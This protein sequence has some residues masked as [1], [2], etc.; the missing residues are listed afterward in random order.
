MI[1]SNSFLAILLSIYWL[2]FFVYWWKKEQNSLTKFFPLF[3]RNNI[4]IILKEDLAERPP[5]NID[6]LLK[7]RT[8]IKWSRDENRQARPGNEYSISVSGEKVK[9]WVKLSRHWKTGWF[10]QIT[11][12]RNSCHKITLLFFKIFVCLSRKRNTI[13]FREYFRSNPQ[14]DGLLWEAE[15]SAF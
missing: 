14:A 1:V 5:K 4:V 3:F 2:Q 8:Y 11:K 9:P 12:I 7:T 6:F 13:S 10:L 15:G